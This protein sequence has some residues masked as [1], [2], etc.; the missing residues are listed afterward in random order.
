MAL[1]ALN[2]KVMKFVWACV[3]SV[4]WRF[5]EEFSIISAD[6]FEQFMQAYRLYPGNKQYKG[7]LKCYGNCQLI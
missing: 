5:G 4:S 6:T 2:F 1:S 3:F 7:M